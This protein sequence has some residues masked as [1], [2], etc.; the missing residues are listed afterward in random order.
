MRERSILFATVTTTVLVLIAVTVGALAYCSYREDGKRQAY[1]Q[2]VLD[3][4]ASAE[5]RFA[6][7][8]GDLHAVMEV[9][10]GIGRSPDDY[11]VVYADTSFDYLLVYHEPEPAGT[12]AGA[13]ADRHRTPVCAAL[14]WD[15]ATGTYRLDEAEQDT[16]DSESGLAELPELIRFSAH[17]LTGDHARATRQRAARQGV[18]IETVTPSQI[19]DE[20]VL[21]VRARIDLPA[22]AG[23]ESAICVLATAR[24]FY[25]STTGEQGELLDTQFCDQ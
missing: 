16:C 17:H 23:H 4:L 2:G 21:T 20:T 8:R 24:L 10:E 5:D 6:R 11:V 7:A 9:A 12:V 3:A 1:R 22:G 15:A 25:D 18:H 14:A 19:D 13:H